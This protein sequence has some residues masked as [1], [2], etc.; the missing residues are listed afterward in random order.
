MIA[1]DRCNEKLDLSKVRAV[2]AYPFL[3]SS[4]GD[5]AKFDLENGRFVSLVC[6][7]CTIFIRRFFGEVRERHSEDCTGNG[8]PEIFF[9]CPLQPSTNPYN[10]VDSNLA[11]TCSSCANQTIF[12]LQKNFGTVKEVKLERPEFIL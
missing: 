12:E 7:S 2:L 9:L 5:D 4:N 3:M 6:E 11:I 10:H 8:Y 1:C